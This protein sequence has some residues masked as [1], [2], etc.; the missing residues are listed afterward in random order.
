MFTLTGK[1]LLGTFTFSTA[2]ELQALFSAWVNLLENIKAFKFN[3]LKLKKV[4]DRLYPHYESLR[5][6]TNLP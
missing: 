4:F 6:F 3:R 5:I 2:L 1:C